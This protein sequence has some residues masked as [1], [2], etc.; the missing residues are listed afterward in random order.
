MKQSLLI[1]CLICG[2]AFAGH[3]S[4]DGQALRASN[5]TYIPAVNGGKPMP[6]KFLVASRSLQDPRF[7]ESVVYL[8]KHG[9]RGTLGLIVNRPGN[10]TLLEVLPGTEDEQAGLH[11]LYYGGPVGQSVV[12]MLLRNE[13]SGRGIARIAGEVSFS[14]E[15]HVLDSMLDGNKPPSEVHF[16]IGHSGWA[17][18]QLR[19]E[20][21]H[22]SWHVIDG[23][24]DMIFS[25]HPKLLWG[26]LIENLEPVGIQAAL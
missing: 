15:R 19:F 26:E 8:V 25:D 4:F 1:I 6:G 12:F 13:A 11:T 23:D 21:Q 7:V 16:H 3:S 9:S 10:V 5:L 17:P 24:A 22:G 14:S 2:V 18:G 20:I